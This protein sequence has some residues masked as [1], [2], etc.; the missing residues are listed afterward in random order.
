MYDVGWNM[1]LAAKITFL[2]ES[3][4]K[5]SL[6]EIPDRIRASRIPRLLPN[7]DLSRRSKGVVFK[8]QY[9]Q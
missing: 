6:H 7:V 5:E 8:Q 9:K 3:S 2:A 1:E 4:F